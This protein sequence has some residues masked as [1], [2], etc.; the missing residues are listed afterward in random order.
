ML[1]GIVKIRKIPGN[2]DKELHKITNRNS[3]N[4]QS[5]K[6]KYLHI[7]FPELKFS[8]PMIS[9]LTAPENGLEPE[10]HYF[11][12]YSKP[13]YDELKSFGN[14]IYY[15]P[16]DEKYAIFEIINKY[17][18]RCNWIFVHGFNNI[19]YLF[20]IKRKYRSKIIWRS[21]GHDIFNYRKENSLKNIVKKIYAYFFY[22]R[23]IRQFRAIG[24]A[25]FIDAVNLERNH[26]KNDSV[27]T[28]N[29]LANDTVLSVA[30]DAADNSAPVRVMIGHSACREDNYPALIDMLE[31]YR[32]NNV[33]FIFPLSYGETGMY[34][35]E[36][37]EKAAAQ[38]GREKC[39][40]L[41]S[42]ML[43]NEY[44][45]FLNH[46]DILILDG[47]GSYA[48]GNISLCILRRKKIF[49]N[50]YGT[51]SEAFRREKLPFSCTDEINN[52]TF[53]EFI[54]PSVY[55][56]ILPKAVMPKGNREIVEGW[57]S[58]LTELEK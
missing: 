49:L 43:Y 31:K 53:E 13:I 10:K 56:D 30:E 35:Q 7:I 20:K 42:I 57:K 9:T 29:Y 34:A 16:E 47:K 18:D 39:E 12:V 8:K 40:F 17:G 25:N 21:W 27:F 23:V 33:R 14:V 4:C 11:M 54:S 6:W 37:K 15:E 50:R 46:I 32:E 52:M 41:D 26:I 24:I 3:D 2:G 44:C 38:L 51:I 48:I 22:L 45:D 58:C 36:V 1:F 55:P 5:E 28:L 19:R